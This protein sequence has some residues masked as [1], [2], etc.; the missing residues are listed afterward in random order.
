MN[1]WNMDYDPARYGR[2][3]NNQI[4]ECMKG[5]NMLEQKG[6]QPRAEAYSQSVQHEQKRRGAIEGGYGPIEEDYKSGFDRERDG[7]GERL[8]FLEAV[9]ETLA[10]RLHPVLL[11][12]GAVRSEKEGVIARPMSQVTAA[13]FEAN[14]RVQQAAV[15]LQDLIER[16]EV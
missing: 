5:A 16:L 3:W 9:V 12:H 15:R 6:T 13:F 11:E 2:N 4:P 8:A 14:C 7:L 1:T 10:G